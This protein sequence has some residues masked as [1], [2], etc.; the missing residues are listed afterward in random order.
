M[1]YIFVHQNF[2]GQ[3]RHLVRMLA[4]DP[5]N[6]VYF[7]TRATANEIPGVHK[8]IYNAPDITPF[9]F[10]SMTA[11]LDYNILTGLAV[12]DVC[13]GLKARGI[14]PNMLIGHCGWG[15]TLFLKDVF[16]DVPVLTYF[17]FYYHLHGVDVD[18]DPEFATVFHDPH[19]LRIKNATAQMAFDA[20]DW[21]NT[22]TQWQYSLHPPEMRQRITVI[23]EGVDTDIVKPDPDASLHIRDRNL[24]LTTK[25]QVVT[26]VARNLEPYRGFHIFMRS[27]PEIQRR[28]PK[29]HTVIVG[30]DGVSYGTPPAPGTCYRQIMLKE[31]DGQLDLSR[32]HFLGNV[33]YATYL[34]ILQISSAHVYL[35]Y[36]FVLSW[37]FIEAMAAGCLVIGSST[38]PVAEILDHEVNGLSV[39]FFSKGQ[40]SETIT[41]TLLHPCEYQDIRTNARTF[42]TQSFGLTGLLAEWRSL[43]KGLSTHR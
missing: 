12:A 24:T 1:I 33:D 17:E 32:I 29:A 39:D 27:L 43:L 38:A 15:E 28:N 13:K 41:G 40:I 26:Y 23:H 42:S 18:F 21:G 16:P 10:H 4:D 30:G 31:L 34:K 20:T 5:G 19:R 6:T 9:R 36:P 35:T 3:Y 25:D 11:D 37:S 2:P 8:I 7:I 22:P 14:Y